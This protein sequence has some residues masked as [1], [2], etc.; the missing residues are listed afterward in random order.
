MGSGFEIK[1]YLCFS[2]HIKEILLRKGWGGGGG[3]SSPLWLDPCCSC[4]NLVHFNKT[5]GHFCNLLLARLYRLVRMKEK[6]ETSQC[7]GHLGMTCEDF[8]VKELSLDILILTE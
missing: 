2:D 4:T 8:Q 6:R 7:S 1:A 3:G 5:S